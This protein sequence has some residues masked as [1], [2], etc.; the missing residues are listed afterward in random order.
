[1]NAELKGVKYQCEQQSPFSDTAYPQGVSEVRR[2]QRGT[3]N[4]APSPIGR[5]TRSAERESSG[6]MS[7][8]TYAV[9]TNFNMLII[10]HNQ[11]THSL[12]EII[13]SLSSLEI[14]ATR[15]TII[16]PSTGF[17]ESR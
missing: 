14:A 8:A 11:S 15:L 10:Y 7:V 12:I 6:E 17:P 9:Y 4:V 2:V 16:I 5:A 3:F 1:M 13:Y